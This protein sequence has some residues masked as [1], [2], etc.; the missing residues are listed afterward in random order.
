[1]IKRILFQRNMSKT[2]PKEK[3]IDDLNSALASELEEGL[4][5]E[6]QTLLHYIES[7]SKQGG[8]GQRQL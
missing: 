1:M 5:S 8:E 2:T 7:L 6:V 3:L 4:K